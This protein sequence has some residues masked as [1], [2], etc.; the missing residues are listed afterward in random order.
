MAQRHKG[1][2]IQYL[3]PA[4]IFLL[5]F[6][7]FNIFNKYHI[8][9]LEQ[10]Q[11]FR[12]NLSY[13]R[14]FFS[15]P[16]ALSL[17]AGAFFTQF[18]IIPWLGALIITLNCLAVYFSTKYILNKYKIKGLVFS[19][20]P[21]WLLVLLQSN[22]LF[23]FDQSAGLMFSLLFVVF[24]ISVATPKSRY[25]L[26]IS[27]WPLY[28][29]LT[30]GFSMICV[31]IC[32]LH[33]ILSGNQKNRF[34]FIFLYLFEGIL[35]P[36]LFS[37][38]LYFVPES[39]I[40]TYP[41]FYTFHTLELVSLVSVYFIL[42]ILMLAGYFAD[43]GNV[44]VL[45]FLRGRVF[46]IISGSL[47]IILMIFIIYKFAYN[48]RAE[49]MF[50]IDYHIRQAE[51]RK[52]LKLAE[53]YPD[54]NTLVIYYT[55]LALLNSGQ[56]GEKMF[57]Y[58]QI[59]PAG[60]RLKWERNSNLVF[61]GEIFYYLAYNNEAYRWAFESMVAKGLNPRSL[62]RLIITS[63]VN[64][65]NDVAKKYLHVLRQA[66]FYRKWVLKYERL[67]SEPEKLEN[68][69]EI[70][71]NKNLLVNKD[72]VSDATGMNLD[73]LLANHPENKMAY[74]YFLA[75]L[76]LNKDLDSFA[77]N[78]SRL[79]EFGYTTIP[80]YFEEA[81]IFYNFY[82]NKKVVPEGFS[83]RPET[84]SRFNE[85]AGIYTKFR[86]DRAAARYE[87]GK[88]FRNTYWYYLQFANI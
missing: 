34:L 68:D 27:V 46:K 39:K 28:Y 16:G 57:A 45:K 33:E 30:G 72:F 20:I 19:F 77:Q 10:N 60:L 42:P 63:I 1:I 59:G 7:Y 26:F 11:L 58:P 71:R 66:P 4:G 22:E 81:L 38:L 51:W 12:F 43:K 14:D 80:L 49:Q 24:Y 3:I 86:S 85:Y 54:L 52:A 40:Y 53:Q 55:N 35:I 50:A 21:V 17:L 8:L 76:L 6:L 65:D 31:I 79:K 70:K 69:P 44:S 73:D 32:A 82:E 15:L 61:G 67:L 88:K 13:L 5:V 18:F 2:V 83:F 56:L 25:I 62:K 78:I 23:T 75:T 64:G 48:R 87:L 47:T 37:R 74:E 41:L 36:W 9:Y 84:I 29:Y